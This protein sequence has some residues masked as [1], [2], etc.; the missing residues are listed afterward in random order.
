[1]ERDV[2][3]VT[4]R[5]LSNSRLGLIP[6][7]RGTASRAPRDG[8]KSQSSTKKSQVLSKADF[9]SKMCSEFKVAPIQ[10]QA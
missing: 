4:S 9:N 8:L 6:E 7:I 3:K 10:D 5:G 1:M 2:E